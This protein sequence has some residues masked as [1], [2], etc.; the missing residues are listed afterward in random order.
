MTDITSSTKYKLL[1]SNRIAVLVVQL[2]NPAVPERQFA[3]PIN[4]ATAAATASAASTSQT[5]GTPEA[6]DCRRGIGDGRPARTN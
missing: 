4:A 2:L 3:H 6:T 5:A 1:T